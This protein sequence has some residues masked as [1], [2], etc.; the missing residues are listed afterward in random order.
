MYM[1]LKTAPEM[2]CPQARALEVTW[3]N[4]ETSDGNAAAINR[5]EMTD[6]KGLPKFGRNCTCIA[7]RCAAWRWAEVAGASEERMTKK[8]RYKPASESAEGE[9]AL[10]PENEPDRAVPVE[11]PRPQDIPAEAA[12]GWDGEGWYGWTLPP[13]EED[14]LANRRAYCGAFGKPMAG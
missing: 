9:H 6:L 3:G 14:I 11:P 2:W 1:T 7:T 5:D 4:S 10:W 13:K 12:W 8:W